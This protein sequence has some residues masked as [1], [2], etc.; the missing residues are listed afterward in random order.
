M[1]TEIWVNIGSDNGLL[2]DGT[3]PLPEPMLTDHQL[4][5]V[6][7]L[8][9]PGHTC[10]ATCRRLPCDLKTAAT[11]A[12]TVRSKLHFIGCRSIG[13]RSATAILKNRRPV[14]EWSATGGRLIANWLEMG[15]DWSATRWRL[16]GEELATDYRTNN[17][18]LG[19]SGYD[20]HRLRPYISNET[21]YNQIWKKYQMSNF[22]VN[23]SDR[24][25][26]G[27]ISYKITVTKL[28]SD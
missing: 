17:L 21:V 27:S 24:F 23:F 8:L 10:T 5:P 28:P 18:L 6:T 26:G 14:G 20:I 3:K 4:S 15:C 12:T 16:V 11:N 9:S 25:D 1:V 22:Q 7:F 19:F 2:P 13:D